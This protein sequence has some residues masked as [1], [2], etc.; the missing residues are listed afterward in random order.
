MVGSS[1][2][3][4]NTVL[5]RKI[6]CYLETKYLKRYKNKYIINS[7]ILKYGLSILRL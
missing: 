4:R 5:N 7:G 1:Y 6:T 2:V 3:G